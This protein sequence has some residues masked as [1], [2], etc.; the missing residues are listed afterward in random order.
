MG[1]TMDILQIGLPHGRIGRADDADHVPPA[2]L[3]SSAETPKWIRTVGFPSVSLRMYQYLKRYSQACATLPALVVLGLPSGLGPTPLGLCVR[4]LASE[5]T[6]DR[7][8]DYQPTLSPPPALQIPLSVLCYPR[9]ITQTHHHHY[10]L[11]LPPTFCS[12][13]ELAQR[14]SPSVAIRG[15]VS[16]LTYLRVHEKRSWDQVYAF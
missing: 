10:Y 14:H 6:F 16:A 2:L 4:V 3:P 1:S 9:P 5:A 11:P 8:P 15:K 12:P 13:I 7:P